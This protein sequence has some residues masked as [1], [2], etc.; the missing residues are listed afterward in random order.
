MTTVVSKGGFVLF[1]SFQAALVSKFKNVFDDK[2]TLNRVLNVMNNITISE[3]KS[4]DNEEKH[5]S[6][7][8]DNDQKDDISDACVIL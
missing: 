3:V 8:S 2:S 5:E 4:F 7:E 6:L 1:S